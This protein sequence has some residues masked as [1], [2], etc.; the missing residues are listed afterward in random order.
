[1]TV[2]ISLNEKIKVKLT[3]F[4]KA[5]Y[6][7]Q[8]DGISK[9]MPNPRKPKLPQEDANGFCSFQLWVFMELYGKYM[10]MGRPNVIDPL[11]ILYE[12]EDE[13]ADTKRST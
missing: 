5:I 8:Y 4:G 13:D 11:V 1:M 10:V 3:D 6:Y 9:C 2:R 7:H 12:M